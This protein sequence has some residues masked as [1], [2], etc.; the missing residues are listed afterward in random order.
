MKPIERLKKLHLEKQI[1][2]NP[3]FPKDYLPSYNGK[4]NSANGIT[5]CI[6]DWLTYHGHHAN[7][8]NTMGTP[9]VGK[10]MINPLTGKVSQSMTWTPSSTQRGT[11]DIKAVIKRNTDR[12]GVPVDIEVKFAKDK[13]SEAQKKY[14]SE[15]TQAG[16][17]YII[18]TTFDG[19]VEWYDTFINK[20]EIETL[21]KIDEL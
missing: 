16:G 6:V 19:F 20:S 10:K 7:R 17:I 9:R 8:I 2:D 13:Q 3:S 12:Y 21:K 14:E 15:F 18:A 1:V 4:P 11:A 5:K